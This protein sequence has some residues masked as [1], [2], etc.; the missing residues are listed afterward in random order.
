MEVWSSSCRLRERSSCPHLTETHGEAGEIT[1]APR[2]PGVPAHGCFFTGPFNNNT[3]PEKGGDPPR[4][5]G[6]THGVLPTWPLLG[7]P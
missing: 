1:G 7:Y 4:D 3:N 5:K 6:P 2:V